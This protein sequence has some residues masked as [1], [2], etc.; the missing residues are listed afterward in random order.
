[1]ENNNFIAVKKSR[2]PIIIILICALLAGMVTAGLLFFLGTGASDYER[3]ERDSMNALF[4]GISPWL[5]LETKAAQSGSISITPSSELASL[6]MFG[7]PDLSGLGSMTFNYDAIIDGTDIYALLGVD[8]LGVRAQLAYWQLGSEMI[9]HLPGISQYYILLSDVLFM[10][11]PSRYNF[12]IDYEA[13][14][15]DAKDIGNAVL[16]RYFE[17]TA[18]LEPAW[19]E[20]VFAGELSRTADVFEVVMDTNFMAEL[21]RAGFEAFLDSDVLLP[22]VRDLYN[23]E[24][25]PYKDRSWYQSFDEVLQ[26]ARDELYG[27]DLAIHG[28]DELMTMRVYVSG[29]DVVRRDIIVE[30]VTFSYTSINERSGEYA[31]SVRFS[32]TDWWGDTTTLTL[33]NEGI[34]DKGYCTGEIL[35]TVDGDYTDRVTVTLTYE[36]FRLYDNGMFGGNINLSVPVEESLVIEVGLNS[37]VTGNSMNMGLSVAGNIYGIELRAKLFDIAITVN[38]DTGKSIT[39]PPL[40]DSNTINADDWMAMW[41][42]QEELELWAEGLDL[43]FIEDLFY[44]SGLGSLLGGGYHY[45]DWDDDYCYDCWGYHYAWEDCYY[46]WDWDWDSGYCY[47]CWT[48]H[49][50][51]EDCYDWDNHD[52]GWDDDWDD[53]D[54]SFDASELN[55]YGGLWAVVLGSD[56]SQEAWDSVVNEYEVELLWWELADEWYSYWAGAGYNAHAIIEIEAALN[57]SDATWDDELMWELMFADSASIEEWAD[58]WRSTFAMNGI[59]F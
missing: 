43:S 11:D 38:P 3:A 19:S 5:S 35:F 9:M 42:F 57:S 46:D 34:S 23:F 7:V 8:A 48:S 24:N 13:L 52:W 59:S 31:K 39:R 21:A 12:D 15:E 25:D 10:G 47:E 56:W 14:L 55:M 27:A 18:D 20:E 1:M 44:S 28:D 29:R 16:D 22:F 4:K 50:E 33:T 6:V 53:W 30:G 40:T 36:D 54:Y 49:E 37:V 2:A 51:W 45:G 58:F 32:Y 41:A 26:E 17:L